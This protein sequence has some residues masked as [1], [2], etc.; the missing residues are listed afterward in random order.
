MFCSIVLESL[1]TSFHDWF[2]LSAK[3]VL[4]LG[5]LSKC[6]R[7]G[8]MN[9]EV[10]APCILMI[11]SWFSNYLLCNFSF[12]VG[13]DF[14]KHVGSFLNQ[15]LDFLAVKK[16]PICHQ[17]SMR[18]LASKKT[19]SEEARPPETIPGWW[20]EDLPP[21]CR[22]FGRK[23]EKEKGRKEVAKLGG[24]GGVGRKARWSTRSSRWVGGLL[25]LAAG[26]TIST[27]GGNNYLLLRWE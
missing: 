19:A 10:S 5:Y 26:I 8:S 18:K 21:R 14:G 24:K 15:L 23:A 7:H 13:S 22:R 11:F 16:S 20:Q 9:F 25:T 3:I 2:K 17:Q 4:K 12:N 6:T 27:N 1:L